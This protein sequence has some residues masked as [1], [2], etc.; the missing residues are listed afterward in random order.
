MLP[1]LVLEP[2]KGEAWIHEIKHDGF[3]TILTVDG[4]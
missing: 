1:S 3:R 4:G 2:P